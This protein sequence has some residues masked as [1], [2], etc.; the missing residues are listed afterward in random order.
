MFDVFY[1]SI[2][3]HMLMMSNDSDVFA[4]SYCFL[5]PLAVE[6]LKC[7]IWHVRSW[8]SC[9]H[10][11]QVVCFGFIELSKV[12]WDVGVVCYGVVV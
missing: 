9:V 1:E 12:C 10:V 8:K 3:S 7:C 11:C 2:L 5:E 4:D 6:D